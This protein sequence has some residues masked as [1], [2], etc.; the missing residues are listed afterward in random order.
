MAKPQAIPVRAL[1]AGFCGRL[2]E[3]GDVFVIHDEAA[4]APSWM[5]RI[6]G[7]AG[8]QAEP[9]TLDFT[10][11]HVPVG[12]WVVV[13]KAGER[14]SRVFKKSE[15]NPKDLAAAEAVRLNAGGQ[16]VL[17]VQP[18]TPSAQKEPASPPPEG[19]NEDDP[20]LPD[21]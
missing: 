18:T 21:A 15:G 11:K 7:G 4:F 2:L 1:A 6:E 9:E 14:A 13:D 10:I 19:G 20:N 3:K 8:V 17:D 5:E 16:P 12:S